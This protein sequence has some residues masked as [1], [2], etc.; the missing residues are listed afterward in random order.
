MKILILILFIS[1]AYASPDLSKVACSE[2]VIEQLSAW[3]ASPGWIKQ[4]EAG[5]KKYFWATPT[6]VIGDWA[7][8]REIPGGV[9]L[10]KTRQHGRIEV[11]MKTPSCSKVVSSYP[12]SE[13]AKNMKNDSDI[14]KFVKGHKRGAIY[15]WS[16]HMGL[17]EKGIAEIKAAS[18]KLKLPLLVLEDTEIDSLEFKMRS[19]DQ[20][21]PAVLVFKD[22]KILSGIKYGHE[23][24][25]R[26]LSDLNSM[27]GT[28]K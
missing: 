24:S 11:V 22:S 27:L 7:L 3:K 1:S 28:G 25:D 16:K 23:K 10:A 5:L 6:D 8:L 18:E 9:V 21:Y 20:H 13:P 19:V 17:S 12:H 15:V 14:E 4:R 2:R 26:Y